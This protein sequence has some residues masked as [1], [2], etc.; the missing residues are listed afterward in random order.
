MP[1]AW[2]RDRDKIDPRRALT[3]RNLE[4][5]SLLQQ[6]LGWDKVLAE[7]ETRVVHDS[8]NRLI[9]QLLE[10]TLDGDRA[11]FL[12]AWCPANQHWVVIRVDPTIETA[13]AASASTYPVPDFLRGAEL[14]TGVRL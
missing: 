1:D 12:R 3:E 11:R 6:I 14:V 7:L 8:G 13:Q 2:I 10:A 9:G 4:H 5:R